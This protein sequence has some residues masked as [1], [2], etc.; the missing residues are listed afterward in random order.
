MLAEACD[1]QSVKRPEL[2]Q[3]PNLASPLACGILRPCILLPQAMVERGDRTELTSAL[4][5]EVAHLARRDVAWTYATRLVQSLLWFQPL[6]WPLHRRMVAAN[7]ELCDLQAV[8]GGLR[9]EA[10]ADCLLR[11]AEAASRPRI[12]GVLGSGM[13]TRRSSLATRI[14]ALFDARRARNTRLSRRTRTLVASSAAVLAGAGGIFVAV[15]AVAKPQQPDRVEIAPGSEA[16]GKAAYD[17]MRRKYRSLKTLSFTF[18]GKDGRMRVKFRR[19]NLIWIER[20]PQYSGGAR[21]VLVANGKNVSFYDENAPREVVVGPQGHGDLLNVLRQ[22]MGIGESVAIHFALSNFSKQAQEEQ[23]AFANRSTFGLSKRDPRVIVIKSEFQRVKS[24]VTF[25]LGAHGL[26]EEVTAQAQSSDGS[27]DQMTQRYSDI[28]VDQPI[29]TEAFRLVTLL[30]AKKVAAAP[31]EPIQTRAA[32][33]LVK[34]IEAAAQGFDSVAFEVVRTKTR[35]GQGPEEPERIVRKIEYRKE[36]HI[37]VEEDYPRHWGDVLLVAN[38]KELWARSE[39]SQKKVVHQA[40][41]DQPHERVRQLLSSAD[42][43]VPQPAFGQLVE[44]SYL[45]WAPSYGLSQRS[46]ETGP[47]TRVDGIPV[48]ALVLKSSFKRPNGSSAPGGTTERI[49]VDAKGFIR[50]ME[51]STD[52]GGGASQREVVEVRNVRLNPVLPDSR[53]TFTI[54]PGF[55]VIPSGSVGRKEA[56]RP[57][58]PLPPRLQMGQAP[59]STRFHTFDG[60][61]MDLASLKGKAVY[62]L[63]WKFTVPSYREDLRRAKELHEK[64]G[65][66]GLV[67]I[68][69]G[70]DDGSGREAMAKFLR[71]RSYPF[72][73]VLDAPAYEGPLFKAWNVRQF[74]FEYII[75]RN[76]IISSHNVSRPGL[77]DAIRIALHR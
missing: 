16:K 68:A 14:E 49:F 12:E 10:Y 66:K 56:D 24:T 23:A 61:T 70:F 51:L 64:Y 75:G 73:N 47:R 22:R 7:E 59:P 20:W 60:R 62:L 72:I 21:Q 18:D 36:G 58:E 15:P 42:Y 54:P 43:R 53:F 45:G 28:R 63:G 77:E 74:P 5:H 6:V 31:L 11:L 25:R 39:K 33:A 29:P 8:Q 71:E 38:G 27:I 26:I 30:P 37:R 3:V 69:V 55:T 48:D 2:R 1:A 32:L 44:M 19:P 41:S 17:A 13:A 40:L 46:M 50:R 65:K 4:A 34:R 35:T 52:F 67:V 57:A 9:R 76:G